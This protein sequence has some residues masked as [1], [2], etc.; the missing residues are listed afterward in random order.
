ML[1]PILRWATDM[2]SKKNNGLFLDL[3]PRRSLEG[4]DETLNFIQGPVFVCYLDDF[5]LSTRDGLANGFDF[6][7]DIIF[8]LG[9]SHVPHY[10]ILSLRSRVMSNRLIPTW[11]RFF[12]GGLQV[13]RG[14]MR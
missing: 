4:I 1:S 9:R 7:Y 10:P 14:I 3:R 11:L 13:S 8:E 6:P 2:E 5:R 12:W